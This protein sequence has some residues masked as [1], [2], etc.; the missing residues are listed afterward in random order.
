[1]SLYQLLDLSFLE[2]CSARFGLGHPT[3]KTPVE[4]KLSFVEKSI[5]R[6]NV[7]TDSEKKMREKDQIISS[8]FG[9]L[10]HLEPV[11]RVLS[12][13][14]V[15]STV[16]TMIASVV[17]LIV[18]FPDTVNKCDRISDGMDNLECLRLLSKLLSSFVFLDEHV[19]EVLSLY[20]KIYVTI[21][22]DHRDII[23]FI[24][25]N[26]F[27]CNDQMK[28]SEKLPFVLRR[29]QNEIVSEMG[30]EYKTTSF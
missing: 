5:I 30:H 7:I 18:Y 10:K 11:G 23:A 22:L 19:D 14:A 2:I 3:F 15:D 6:A 9:F 28:T 26:L 4:A 24:H 29:I 1:M 16:H 12:M 25:E 27:D 8:L 20:P 13:E 17:M 21:V